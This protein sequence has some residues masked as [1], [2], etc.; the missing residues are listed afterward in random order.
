MSAIGAKQPP[1]WRDL[2]RELP[3]C[4]R[5]RVVALSQ[6]FSMTWIPCRPMR[7]VL[8]LGP[9]RAAKDITTACQHANREGTRS[10]RHGTG[11]KVRRAATKENSPGRLR[12][13]S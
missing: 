2:A 4:W 7:K 1:A 3:T 12:S 8:S 13:G 10:G 11:C 5:R 6:L 9:P